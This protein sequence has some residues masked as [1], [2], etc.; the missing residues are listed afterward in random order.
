M[1]ELLESG[2]LVD[3]ALA[4]VV[5]EAA[6][7]G[8]RRR[9]G[10]VPLLDVVGQLLA[11]ALLLLALRS[12]LTGASHVWTLLLLSASLPAHLFDLARRARYVATRAP[13]GG[14]SRPSLS[15]ATDKSMLS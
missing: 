1:K 2:R 5:M 13:S 15:I 7:L 9:A 8:W 4:L 12:A 14:I 3:I 10:G 11:G 6:V